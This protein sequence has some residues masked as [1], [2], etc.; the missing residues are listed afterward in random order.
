M[1]TCRDDKG[2]DFRSKA[3]K[4]LYSPPGAVKIVSYKDTLKKSDCWK[5]FVILNNY[6]DLV[7]VAFFM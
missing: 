3:S 4:K 1:F 6:N 2:D 5:L 7:H